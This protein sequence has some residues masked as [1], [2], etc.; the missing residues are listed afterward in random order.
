M[1]KTG[2]QSHSFVVKSHQYRVTFLSTCTSVEAS[3]TTT[4][5]AWDGVSTAKVMLLKE[6]GEKVFCVIL[7]AMSLRAGL[8]K[9]IMKR[10]TDVDGNHQPVKKYRLG[11]YR[12]SPVSRRYLDRSVPVTGGQ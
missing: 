6:G 8:I 12:Q 3:A 1:T 10:I 7:A 11:G 5:R 4:E 2:L 9:V